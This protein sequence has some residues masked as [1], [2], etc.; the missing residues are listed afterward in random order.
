MELKDLDFRRP[1]SYHLILK[2]NYV[3]FT[4]PSF[5]PQC[6]RIPLSVCSKKVVGTT[7]LFTQA[8]DPT[9]FLASERGIVIHC[10]LLLPHT[11]ELKQEGQAFKTSFGYIV[12]LSLKSKTNMKKRKGRKTKEGEYAPDILEEKGAT[13]YSVC[14]KYYGHI[15]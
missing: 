10:C 1:T 5:Q 14:P 4:V 12:S 6:F 13:S 3:P 9:D 15:F 8:G 11:W 2:E 7:L